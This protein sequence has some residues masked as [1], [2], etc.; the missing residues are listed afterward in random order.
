MTLRIGGKFALA[1]AALVLLFVVLVGLVHLLGRNVRV[2]AHDVGSVEVPSALLSVS[3]IDELDDMNANVL[4][5]VHGESDELEDFERNRRKFEAFY[6]ELRTVSDDEFSAIAE[7]GRLVAVY[8]HEARSR[9]FERFDPALEAWASERIDTL[10]ED[11]AKP[12][13][14]LLNRRKEREL[15]AARGAAPPGPGEVPAASLYVELVDEVGDMR[16]K[17]H[18]YV[19][20]VETAAQRFERDARSFERFL[21]KLRPLEPE[22]LD[23]IER[24]YHGLRDGAR[25]IFTRY[26]ATAKRDALAAIDALEH[27]VF[28][29]IE[30]RLDALAA[31]SQGDSDAA[32]AE[33]LDLVDAN[34]RVLWMALGLMLLV[35][36]GVT[37]FAHSAIARPI[38]DLH[39]MMA[40]LTKGETG[41][42]V[43]HTKRQDEIG[44]MAQA[45]QLFRDNTVALAE[46]TA[47]LEALP[48]K[49]GK[50]LSPQV[51]SSIFRGQKQVE[52]RAERKKLTI[53]F[54][55]VVD[56][57]ETTHDLESEEVA[58]LLNSFLT[59]MTVIALEHG[60]TI[61]KYIGDA[62]L[63]FFGD[64]ETRGVQE[65][66]RACV[67][68]ALAMQKRLQQLQQEW[69]DQGYE[70][71]LR[72]RMGINT[73]YC[74]VGN[75]GSPERMD[76]TIIGGEVNLAARLQ[77]TAEPGGIVLSHETWA[78]TQDL[79]KAE[80]GEPIHV[81]GIR[82]EV[83][84]YRVLSEWQELEAE[85][86][87]LRKT[88]PGLELRIDLQ[89]LA[90]TADAGSGDVEQVVHDLEGVLEAL[91][92]TS[93]N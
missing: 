48:E 20:G 47:D 72:A 35:A 52:V 56:F 39:D 81:K 44:A 38:Q 31:A 8:E 42:D 28:A 91:R 36:S 51:Y 40:A 45:V 18:E 9:V 89:E 68:M 80:R 59:E 1:Q 69:H 58:A 29:D 82:R 30:K 57:T 41:I 74:D 86:H 22:D 77:S 61:D 87:V 32:L 70:R 62:L 10:E 54:S 64:P 15:G 60:A 66:A 63:I 34:E 67:R 24:L 88:R 14:Q 55:D 5:Y 19:R 27:G 93:K 7:L 4:E 12:L 90:R 33:L 25:E 83:I 76:Y 53:F 78:L 50:Y 21:A 37:F 23:R 46:K 16:R 6:Q 43:A 84:P 75:F 11:F 92:K 65:D 13:E 49:L 79:V 71:P 3:L 26:D 17:L 2:Q 85:G 73:G